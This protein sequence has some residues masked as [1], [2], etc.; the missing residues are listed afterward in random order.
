MSRLCPFGLG[1]LIDTARVERVAARQ[2]PDGQH[3]ASE[4][5]EAV[6]GL[7]SVG[8][9][10]GIEAACRRAKDPRCL[11]EL[12]CRERQLFHGLPGS[13]AS[14]LV[15]RA[16]ARCLPYLRSAATRQES[17]AWRT[18]CQSAVSALL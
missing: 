11:V 3:G 4:K 13:R 7:K 8:R 6:D 15:W 18:S 14:A 10:G 17:T 16:W 5:T 2:P 12:Q 9:T 1:Y